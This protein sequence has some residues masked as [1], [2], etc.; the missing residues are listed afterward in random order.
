[1][2]VAVTLP[3]GEN[4]VSEAS[5]LVW[6][7]SCQSC[8]EVPWGILATHQSLRVVSQEPEPESVAILSGV[9]KLVVIESLV[10]HLFSI[11]LGVLDI[12]NSIFVVN[13]FGF[14]LLKLESFL[15][16]KDL[17]FVSIVFSCSVGSGAKVDSDECLLS[18][19]SL[20]AVVLEEEEEAFS[21]VV[22]DIVV[23]ERFF[24]VSEFDPC[25]GFSFNARVAVVDEV[26]VVVLASVLER[27]S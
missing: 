25:V 1:M 26:P 18:E 8:Q 21:Q 19:V 6:D 12:F 3:D 15:E 4:S 13:W 16:T 22:V 5:V 17:I 23:N 20:V 27:G 9:R 11:E 24:G 10:H 7:V 2:V 14:L